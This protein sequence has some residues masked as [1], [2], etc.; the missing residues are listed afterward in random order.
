MGEMPLQEIQEKLFSM[1]AMKS[2]EE[3]PSNITLTAAP[4]EQVLR[5]VQDLQ[6]K[7][8]IV[9]DFDLKSQRWTTPVSNPEHM[10]KCVAYYGDGVLG[11]YCV[12]YAIGCITADGKAVEVDFIEK[13]CDA[14]DDL[15][16]KFLPIIVDA[17]ALYGLYLNK[18]GVTSVE[19]FILV[20]P[21]PDK[22][23]YYKKHGFELVDDY[24]NGCSAMV[25][26][27]IK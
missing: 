26:H 1:S 6:A 5:D 7:R 27:L 16:S 9:W 19:K 13:R 12:G 8:L 3:L 10:I 2:S 11:Y 20:N 21:V 24:L 15:R 17:F 18:Q 4:D 23:G 25:K 22:V 14:S